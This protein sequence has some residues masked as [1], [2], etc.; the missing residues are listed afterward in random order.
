MTGPRCDII[1]TRDRGIYINGTKVENLLNLQMDRDLSTGHGETR[2]T[3]EIMPTSVIFGDVPNE[4]VDALSEDKS[5]LPTVDINRA[6]ARAQARA[7]GLDP[8][9]HT[10]PAPTPSSRPIPAR[11]ARPGKAYADDGDAPD[12]PREG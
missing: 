5:D 6:I 1:V 7:H 11:K 2:V 8:D 9:L 3:I 10:S 12:Y 4:T